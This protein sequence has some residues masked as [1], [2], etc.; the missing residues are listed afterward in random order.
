MIRAHTQIDR[1]FVVLDNARIAERLACFGFRLA[2]PKEVV[3]A[4]ET[5]ESLLQSK[6]TPRHI[7]ERIH[8][9]TRATVWVL[10][11]PRIT[12]FLLTIPLTSLGEKAMRDGSFQPS[13]PSPAHAC[14]PGE[15]CFG[16]YCWVYGGETRDDRRSVM[17]ACAILRVELIPN[18]PIFARGATDDGI[19]SMASLGLTPI[20]NAIPDLYVQEPISRQAD[21]A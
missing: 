2:Q 12:G 10:G 19:R 13:N 8:R 1:A 14:T 5:A 15:P 21:A 16:Y 4:L 20:H 11:S 3:P 18:L 17:T 7:V 6:L 9:H